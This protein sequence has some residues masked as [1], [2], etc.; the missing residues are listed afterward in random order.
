[1]PGPGQERELV[2]RVVPALVLVL[3][4]PLGEQR[5]LALAQVPAQL[6]WIQEPVRCGL[7]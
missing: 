6:V 1:M 7:R 4:P 3:S 5:V 2:E